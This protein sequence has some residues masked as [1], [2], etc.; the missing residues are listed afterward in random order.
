MRATSRGVGGGAGGTGGGA[1]RFG[2]FPGIVGDE[3][4]AGECSIAL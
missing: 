1:F 4:E 2:V 3:G